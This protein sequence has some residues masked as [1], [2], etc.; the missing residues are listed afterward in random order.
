MEN[1]LKGNTE[2]LKINVDESSNWINNIEK[3][4][5]IVYYLETKEENTDSI[6][7]KKISNI[8][9]Y[10]SKENICH[11]ITLENDK[12]QLFKDVFENKDIKKI[13]YKQKLDYI[14]LKENN[15]KPTG[16]CYDIEIAAYIISP[17][18]NKYN[19]EKLAIDYLKLDINEYNKKEDKQ[20]NL[21]DIKEE[22]ENNQQAEKSCMYAYII[23]GIY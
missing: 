2:L 9:I 3:D 15:I 4:K 7:N 16:F 20:I 8:T 23:N 19:L 18:E 21:F 22:N 12:I 13:G 10:N 6:I 5:E 11:H 17:T 1:L 14:L